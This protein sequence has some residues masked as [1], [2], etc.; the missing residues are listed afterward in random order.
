MKIARKL[1]S[2]FIDIHQNRLVTLLEQMTGMR[3]GFG[4]ILAEGSLQLATRYRRPELAMAAEGLDLFCVIDSAGLCVFFSVRYLVEQNLMVKPLGITDLLNGATGAG[5]TPEEVE[6][7]G[8]RI[9]NAER[10]FLLAAGFTRRDDTLL[11]IPVTV[12]AVT[13]VN[14]RRADAATRL[15]SGDEVTLAPPWKA[16]ELD[17]WVE[18]LMPSISFDFLKLPNVYLLIGVMHPLLSLT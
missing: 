14:G 5:Y 10:L 3:Q 17:R 8:E 13:L 7:V 2:V 16:V 12:E 9:F 6:R 18:I 4:N 11:R 15:N 1:F